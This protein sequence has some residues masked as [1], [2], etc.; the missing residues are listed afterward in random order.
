MVICIVNIKVYRLKS[1]KSRLAEKEKKLLMFVI[2]VQKQTKPWKQSLQTDS[3]CICNSRH[4]LVT[5]YFVILFGKFFWLYSRR[6][7]RISFSYLFPHYDLYAA[8]VLLALNR[9]PL[10]LVSTS[11]SASLFTCRV[12]KSNNQT[13]TAGKSKL[14]LLMASWM[15]A[16]SAMAPRNTLSASSR[17]SSGRSD[18]T[19][20]L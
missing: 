8:H 15:V 14:T 6:L 11:Q 2:P 12:G 7:Q 4:K 19:S 5:C 13:K 1:L 17:M 20:E 10:N 16:L 9:W 3:K 18:S